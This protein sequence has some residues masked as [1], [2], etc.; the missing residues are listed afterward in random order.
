MK[1]RLALLFVKGGPALP[2]LQ[3]GLAPGGVALAYGLDQA[4]MRQLI[5]RQAAA[6]LGANDPGV[7]QCVDRLGRQARV[8]L[9]AFLHLA[10]AYPAR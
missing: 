2:G 1:A 9:V 4:I 3:A 8:G 7:N 5:P 10:R 6:F